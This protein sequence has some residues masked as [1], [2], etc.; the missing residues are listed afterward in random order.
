MLNYEFSIDSNLV[1]NEFFFVEK[2]NNYN[3]T[4]NNIFS[5]LIIENYIYLLIIVYKYEKAGNRGY[6]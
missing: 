3:N 2:A 4:A 6:V 1:K 5:F